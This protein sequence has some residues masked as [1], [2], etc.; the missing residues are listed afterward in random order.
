MV[1]GINSNFYVQNVQESKPQTIQENRQQ[2]VTNPIDNYTMAG[3]ESLGIYNMSLIKNKKDFEHKPAE[4]ILP[5]NTEMNQVEGK[6]QSRYIEYK[7]DNINGQYTAKVIEKIEI[8]NLNARITSDV[9]FLGENYNNLLLT[10]G[11]TT[12]VIVE[13][14][15]ASRN[16]L[17]ELKMN[18]G[19]YLYRADKMPLYYDEGRVYSED[20]NLKNPN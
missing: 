14:E 7:I 1:N 11:D 10:Y 5:K 17:F 15:K 8:D 2:A 3:L 19:S 4:L 18:F 6:K 20:C 12:K 16:K 13:I 9:D